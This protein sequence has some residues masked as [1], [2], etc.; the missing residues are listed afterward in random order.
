MQRIASQI[1]APNERAH[2]PGHVAELI[3]MSRRDLKILLSGQIEKFDCLCRIQGERLLNIEVAA[4]F[5]A[6]L[7][8]FK[9]ALWRRGD[10]HHIG[11]RLFKHLRHIA[12]ISL[13]LEALEQL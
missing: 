4:M 10:V 6:S 7:A 9:V 3:V 11:L 13:D 1:A 12:E 2:A 8:D 5:Q